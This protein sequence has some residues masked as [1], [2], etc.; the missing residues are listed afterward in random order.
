MTADFDGKTVLVTGA[1]SG[2]GLAAARLFAERGATVC[3][4]DRDVA[5]GQRAEADMRDDG[6]RAAFYEVDV[7]D[8]RSVETMIGSVVERFGRLDC[9]FNNAGISG[10]HKPFVD[11]TLAEWQ[12]IIDVDLTGVFLCMREELRH[13]S[14][15]GG[16]AIVNT[17][18][19]AAVFATRG[20][21]GYSAAKHGVLGLTMLGAMECG[22]TGVRVNA[23]MPGMTATPLFQQWATEHPRSAET[24]AETVPARRVASPREV[25]ETAVWLCSP[26]ASYVNGISMLVDGGLVCR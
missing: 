24:L 22:T 12:Q 7:A 11:H 14:G 18:S 5:A 13:M 20:Q 16:G 8:E 17:S 3:V 9:A 25:A 6:H 1:A 2:I 19:G 4:G 10:P 26:G 21:P 23:I 15:H